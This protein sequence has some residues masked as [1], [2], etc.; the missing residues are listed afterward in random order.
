MFLSRYVVLFFFF[1]SFGGQLF[2]QAIQLPKEGIRSNALWPIFPGG[3]FRFAYRRSLHDQ[4]DWRTDI[5]LGIGHSVP[6]RRATEGTFSETSAIVGIRQFLASPWHLEM[7][8][9]YGQ[10]TLSN[11]VSPGPTNVRTLAL[12]NAGLEY[13]AIDEISRQKNFRSMDL[14]LMALGGYEWK[15]SEQWSL[16]VQAGFAKVVSKSNPWPIYKDTNRRETISESIIPVA[17]L[18]V[19][20]WF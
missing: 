4:L 9:A 6:E 7:V 2:A 14:E 20:Y 13:Y 17:T 11:A 1:I 18:H 15:L 5:L 8:A 19:T 10:S 16:D 12:L 3:K